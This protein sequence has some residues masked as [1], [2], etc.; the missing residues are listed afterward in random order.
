[1]IGTQPFPR[2][3]ASR[4]LK[5]DVDIETQS[6]LGD[7]TGGTA[8]KSFAV[9]LTSSRFT[10]IWFGVFMYSSAIASGD[11][12]R[13]D[14][15]PRFRHDPLSLRAAYPA[16][17]CPAL[18]ISHRIVLD[19]DLVMPPIAWIPRRWQVSISNCT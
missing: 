13:P 10:W 7:L 3:Q 17:L 18:F 11:R 12:H 14:A 5:S 4:I 8:N 16:A 2:S 1:M 19:G 9:T 6:V 15:P